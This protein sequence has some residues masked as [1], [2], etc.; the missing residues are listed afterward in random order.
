V[1]KVIPPKTFDQPLAWIPRSVDNSSGGQLWVDDKRWGPLSGRMIHTSFGQG[2][3][4]Y[5]L[6]Q[7]VGD[8]SQAAV[9]RLPHMF[10]TGIMRLR[11]NPKDGQVYATGL[12]GWNGGGRKKGLG[13]GG[14]QR[15]RYTGKALNMITKW[16]VEKDGIRLDFNFSV[17]KS[18]SPASFNIQ[19]WNYKWAHNYG[20]K[21]YKPSDG[22]VGKETV[23][24]KKI[25]LSE[26]GKSIKLFIPGIKPVNQIEATINI[27]T[28]EGAEFK[29]Q[30]WMTINK[31][32][33]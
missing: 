14:I 24:I 1:K 12:N 2:R 22:K 3:M 4:Y 29:E 26:N 7:D 32:P 15:V 5:F 27:K 20:S 16:A 31:V 17:D 19:Q 23:E 25:L 11:V 21:Q 10:N 13:E 6:I 30:M 33:E 28:A 9:I 8:I 18:I